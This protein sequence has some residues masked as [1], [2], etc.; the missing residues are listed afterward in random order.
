MTF[1]SRISDSRG[2]VCWISSDKFIL[3]IKV[4]KPYNYDVL[5]DEVTAPIGSVVIRKLVLIMPTNVQIWLC[6]NPSSLVRT[7]IRTILQR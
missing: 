5:A 6:E 4:K 3:F 1:F 7:V 2:A